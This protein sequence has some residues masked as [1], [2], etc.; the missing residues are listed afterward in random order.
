MFVNNYLVRFIPTLTSLCF[1]YE[2]LIIAHLFLYPLL[3]HVLKQYALSQEPA[4]KEFLDNLFAF[5]SKEGMHIYIQFSLHN[6]Y[7]CA[8]VFITLT[9]LCQN[10][11]FI[12]K[13]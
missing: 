5:L 6:N 9:F 8:C 2:A 1:P 12:I 7:M 10:C 3:Q 13:F 11:V 4:R